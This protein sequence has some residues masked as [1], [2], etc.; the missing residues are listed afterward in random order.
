MSQ[1]PLRD[2]TY[3]AERLGLSVAAIYRLVAAKQIAHVDVGTGYRSHKGEVGYHRTVLRFLD[4]DIDA[5]I[6]RRRVP[7]ATPAEEAPAA[8]R[9]VATPRRRARARA[10]V[11]LPGADRYVEH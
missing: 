6:A 11:D 3:A 5:F 4:A 2:V 9:L 10:V 8:P 1:G 7:S